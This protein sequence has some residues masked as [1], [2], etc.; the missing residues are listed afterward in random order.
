MTTNGTRSLPDVKTGNEVLRMWKDGA[1]SQEFFL[2]ENRQRTGF[3]ANL[4]GEG[5]KPAQ[6][7]LIYHKRKR[8]VGHVS[9]G[10]WSP[11][12]KRDIALAHVTTPYAAERPL[13]LSAE[14]YTLEE[15][16]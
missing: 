15:G 16:R 4:P 1:A 14:I 9:S 3:D 13:R 8:E 6:G 10:I 12:A 5:F 7:A 11:T 2:V